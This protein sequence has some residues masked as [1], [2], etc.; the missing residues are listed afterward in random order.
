MRLEKIT[1]AQ[2]GFVLETHYGESYVAKTLVEAAEL[3]GESIP[4]REPLPDVL[5]RTE[6]ASGHDGYSLNTV[7]V[8]AAAGQKIDAI[9]LLRD[10]YKPALGLRVAKELIEAMV[11]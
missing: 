8:L 11:R 9:K 4:V 6:Y 5:S 10:M 1:V 2:N 7:K 3:C